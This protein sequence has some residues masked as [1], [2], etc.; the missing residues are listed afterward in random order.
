MELTPTRDRWTRP[1]SRFSSD[2]QP[3]ALPPDTAICLRCRWLAPFGTNA[4][5][6][7]RRHTRTTAHPT[8]YRPVRAEPEETR[9]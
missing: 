3:L 8:V 1:A 7:A 6:A 9:A 4:A 2:R 5:V